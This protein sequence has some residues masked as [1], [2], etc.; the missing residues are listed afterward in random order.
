MKDVP[1]QRLTAAAAADLTRRRFIHSTG[2]LG[3]LAG[4][5][6]LLP[7][8]AWADSSRRPIGASSAEELRPRMVNGAAVYD[9][10]IAETAFTVAGRRTTATTVNGTVP[11]P[12]LR[13]REG[14]DAILRVTNRLKEDTSIHWH[15]ILLPPEMDGVPGLS[16][17]GIRPGE[18][19]EY[20]FPVLQNGTYW[21]HS[22]SGLQEQLGH[23]G[24]LVVDPADG[25]EGYPYKFDREYVVVLSDWTFENPYKVLSRLKKQPD[26]YNYQKRTVFDFF[27]DVGRDGFMPTVR[28]RLMWAGMR[29]NPTDIHDVTGSTYTFLMN[30]LAPE[31]NWTGLFRPGERVLLRFINASAAT[32]FDVRIPGLPMTVVQASGQYVQPVETDEIR[33]AIAETYDV[34]IEPEADAA[35]TLF[36][37]SMDR[38]GYAAGTFAPREGMSAAIPA[39][40]ERPILTMADMGMDHGDMGGAHDMGGMDHDNMAGMGMPPAGQSPT[41]MAA[42][43]AAPDSTKSAPTGHEGHD[44]SA[45]A[46]MQMQDTPPRLAVAGAIRTSGLRA[47]GTLPEMLTHEAST[48][49]PGNAAVP[50][51]V[52]SRLA[53]P[54]IGLGHDGWRVLLY[55]DLRALHPRADFGAPE[56]EIELHLTGNMERF[57]W[58]IDGVPFEKSEPIHFNHGERLRLTMVNDTMMNHPMHLHGMWMEL[59]N[60]HGELIPRVH[61]VNV[62]PAEHISLLITADAPGK[63]AFHCHVLYHMDA[64]MF[65]VVE[66]S[67]R[68]EHDGMKGHRHE[69]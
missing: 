8:Y 46:G 5:E 15:G 21:Y 19:F 30:G 11:G 56:R 32:Y 35:Y 6:A 42:S 55:T 28:D 68:G 65:R 1:S 12:L 44:M 39:R 48:H 59:E 66:V 63:W 18:T 36:A 22:H 51:M 57:M 23:F 2:A 29:M 3:L 67:S 43:A 20:R 69:G 62:K 64:G 49:G 27:K 9:L 37:E 25:I 16:F 14:E 41:S 50:E 34:I 31:A 53:E 38:S 4:A 60:G 24:P 40:R 45:M 13:L 7:S 33:I 17:P 54:G 52:Q 26:Y 10:T 58:S 47:P 61:T